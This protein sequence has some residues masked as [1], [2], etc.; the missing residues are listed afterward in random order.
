MDVIIIIII[1]T[2]CCPIAHV[3]F[4]ILV[5]LVRNI[6]INKPSVFCL[7]LATLYVI[8]SV[9]SIALLDSSL[10]LLHFAFQIFVI[11]YLFL[12]LRKLS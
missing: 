7:K 6:G 10:Y 4:R 11:G 9:T 1:N 8:G 2:T 12:K 5:S 3:V